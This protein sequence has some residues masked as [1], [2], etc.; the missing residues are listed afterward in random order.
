MSAPS[1]SFDLAIGMVTAPRPQPLADRTLSELRRAGFVQTIHVF[2]EPESRVTPQSNV[3]LHRHARRLGMWGNWLFAA[4]S[5]LRQCES[6]FV[7]IC[8]D[9]LSLAAG[10]AEALERAAR[11]LPLEDWGYASLYTSRINPRVHACAAGWQAIPREDLAWGSLTY[12]FTRAAL[13]ELLHEPGIVTYR[14]SKG[15]DY[16]VTTAMRRLGR[17]RY[18]HVP[19]LCDHAD[20]GGNSTVG[21][22]HSL[23][24]SGLGFDPN[25]RSPS[26][27]SE[28]RHRPLVSCMMVT[29][30]RREFAL[31]AIRYF[32]RQTY[33]PRELV[34][35]DDGRDHL[36][37]C[38]PPDDRLRYHHVAPGT[39][40]GA[41]RNIACSM[42]RGSIVVFWDDDDWYAP[43]RLE[44]QVLPLLR[45]EGEVS[46]LEQPHYFDL[47][48][49]SFWEASEE[50]NRELWYQ[51]V[52]C[53]TLAFQRWL[54]EGGC[55]F[56]DAWLGEEASF[57]REALKRGARLVPVAS[58]GRFLYVRHD[59]NSWRFATEGEGWRRR[60]PVRL[61]AEDEQFYRRR[62]QVLVERARL[63]ALAES[64]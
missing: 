12:C 21:H 40:I 7:L 43:E 64:A 4:R 61:P 13:S 56:P 18:Y 10:A 26:P 30:D 14:E 2:A 59:F 22:R 62:Q 37:A 38:L 63:E 60:E 54:W 24:T 48:G 57:L 50:R 42:A 29:R 49:W 1:A 53:G 41:K 25:Y 19:S 23:E 11:T 44:A 58:E 17:R 32:Q 45:E 36:R 31:Q 5:L 6:P 47:A 8:E 20:A 46:A 28:P 39:S 51:N 55:H 15:T 35:V 52:H 34:I 16:V 9:D 27:A 3:V 33:E